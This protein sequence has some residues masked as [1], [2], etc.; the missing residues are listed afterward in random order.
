MES[1]FLVTILILNVGPT[2]TTTREFRGLSIPIPFDP[3]TFAAAQICS[4]EAQLFE[5]F[6]YRMIN[7]SFTGMVTRV[8]LS[9]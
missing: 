6:L 1:D 2:Y 9:R 7:K 3:P 4:L 8:S 5:V